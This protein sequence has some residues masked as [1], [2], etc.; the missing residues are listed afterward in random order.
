MQLLA[1]NAGSHYGTT[2]PTLSPKLISRSKSL[3]GGHL[4]KGKN[5]LFAYKKRR[6]AGAKYQLSLCPLAMGSYT[7]LYILLSLLKA[8]PPPHIFTLRSS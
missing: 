8:K 3:H 1:W 4:L 6:L 2:R 7:L 5:I